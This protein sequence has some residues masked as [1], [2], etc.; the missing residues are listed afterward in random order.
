M[1]QF[2]LKHNFYVQFNKVRMPPC[3]EG[4]FSHSNCVPSNTHNT[5]IG[6]GA[7]FRMCMVMYA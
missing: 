1:H 3:R 4:Y 6:P 2:S 5:F 7:L